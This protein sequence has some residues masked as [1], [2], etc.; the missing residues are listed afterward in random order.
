M[1]AERQPQY[2]LL[3]SL[4]GFRYHDLR[5]GEA[6]RA[7]W[8]RLFSLTGVGHAPAA[9]DPRGL[10]SLSDPESFPAACDEVTER[11]TLSWAEGAGGSLLTIALDH[12]TLARAALYA[13]MLCGE[14]PPAE[15]VNPA[16]DVLRRAGNQD[17]LPRG[18]LTRAL[19]RAVIGDFDGAR[20]DLDEAYE[21][22]ER[23]PMRLFLAD[24]RLHR[25]RLFGLSPGRPTAYPWTSPR[26]D[27]AE[28]RKLIETYGYGR[29]L[30][31]LEDAEATFA[32][33]DVAANHPSPSPCLSPQRGGERGR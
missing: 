17:D 2:P 23:G 21:I 11:Q 4:P 28:A 12:L 6:E 13:A 19:H 31:E 33:I 14:P 5:L 7:A 32:T 16:V 30:G 27:L 8:R 22:A 25:A 26:A 29:R 18:L 3:Y 9:V 24:I 15:H 10:T 1:Q 20:E